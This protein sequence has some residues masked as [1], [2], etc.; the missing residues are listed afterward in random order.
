MGN[1]AIYNTEGL[2]TVKYRILEIVQTE[3]YTKLIIDYDQFEYMKNIALNITA[4]R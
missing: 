1:V 4:G 2:N 3:L